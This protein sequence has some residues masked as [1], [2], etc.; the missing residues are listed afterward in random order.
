[1]GTIPLIINNLVK[2]GCVLRSASQKDRRVCM[3][4]LTDKGRTLIQNLAPKNEEII[5]DSLRVLTKEE[6]E[7]LLYLMKKLGGKL[8]EEKST[9]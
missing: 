9:K 1:M 8:N 6:Q 2:T 4:S 3:V 7:E 5:K